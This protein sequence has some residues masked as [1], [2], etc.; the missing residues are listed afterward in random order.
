MHCSSYT[1]WLHTAATLAS[2][3]ALRTSYLT[4]DQRIVNV[5]RV[6]GVYF[7]IED[8]Y[9]NITSED[10]SKL[11]GLYDDIYERKYSFMVVYIIS[12]RLDGYEELESI[13]SSPNKITEEQAKRCIEL[14]RNTDAIAYTKNKL[15]ELKSE[16][17]RNE[18]FDISQFL[19]M[20]NKN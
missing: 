20:Q 7:Q 13:F 8:D 17:R 9:I 1:Y 11:K 2:N 6:Y 14:M 15:E 19:S 12:S 16:L 10:F 18:D 3:F 5:A 4:I